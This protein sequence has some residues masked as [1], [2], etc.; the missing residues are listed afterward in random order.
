[1]PHRVAPQVGMTSEILPLAI[2]FGWD[3]FRDNHDEIVIADIV[4][5]IGS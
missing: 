5:V 4:F 3:D 2:L 1:M